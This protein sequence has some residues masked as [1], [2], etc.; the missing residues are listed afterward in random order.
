MTNLEATK[1]L[2]V[3]IAEEALTSAASLIEPATDAGKE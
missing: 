2:E 1:A 3:Q